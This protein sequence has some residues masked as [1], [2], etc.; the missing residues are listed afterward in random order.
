M[1]LT[2]EQIKEVERV[3]KSSQQGKPTYRP[4]QNKGRGVKRAKY[5]HVPLE[6][7]GNCKRQV[8][9]YVTP[10]GE[11][12]YVVTVHMEKDGKKYCKATGHGPEAKAR[13][14]GWAELSD[15][16]TV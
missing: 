9:E 8:D 2:P 13:T 7:C 3:E 5:E 15:D 11:P 10:A 12:G 4:Y 16:L 6:D 14:H 1:E